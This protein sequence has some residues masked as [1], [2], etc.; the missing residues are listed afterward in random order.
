MKERICKNCKELLPNFMYGHCYSSNCIICNSLRIAPD[1]TDKEAKKFEN[2]LNG[3]H[4]KRTLPKQLSWNELKQTELFKQ[5]R[6]GSN[7]NH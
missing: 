1:L 6:N 7:G 4:Q 3:I 5:L 2:A